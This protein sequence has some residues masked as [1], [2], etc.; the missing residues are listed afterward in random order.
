M[1]SGGNRPI[2]QGIETG[3][4]CAGARAGTDQVLEDHVPTNHEGHKL[5]YGHVRV[6][7]SRAGCVWYS[8]TKFGITCSY[9]I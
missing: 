9:K 5:A 8:N 6:H 1:E 2:S 3:T 4:Q 7:V